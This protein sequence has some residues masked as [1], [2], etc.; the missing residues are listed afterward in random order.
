MA[1]ILAV[2]GEL[3]DVKT[4][5]GERRMLGDLAESNVLSD[6][7]KNELIGRLL[8]QQQKADEQQQTKKEYADAS[9]RAKLE[10]RRRLRE[11]KTKEEAL[12]KEMDA[13]SENRVSH[14][15]F[16]SSTENVL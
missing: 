15:L 13:L 4:R 14:V 6:E 10:A 7:Q 3:S 5:E 2:T 11:E 16:R 8:E 1:A 12:R 9:L